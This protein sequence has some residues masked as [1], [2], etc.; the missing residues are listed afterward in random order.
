MDITAEDSEGGPRIFSAPEMQ[1]LDAAV[2]PE[3]GLDIVGLL[4]QAGARAGDQLPAERPVRSNKAAAK[5]KRPGAPPSRPQTAKLGVKDFLELTDYTVPEFSVVAVKATLGR[6]A[7]AFADL[8][9]TRNWMRNVPRRDGIGFRRANASLV[10][11][12]AV[13][14]NPWTVIIRSIFRLGAEDYAL[15]V[16]DAKALS[17]RLKTKAIAFVR[18]SKAESVGYD[19]FERGR[20]AEHAQWIERGSVCWFQSRFRRKP[21][22][23]DLPEQ[24]TDAVFRQQG[25]YLPACYPRRRGDRAWLCA[26]KSSAGAIQRADV[27]VLPRRGKRKS[28]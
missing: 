26:E 11:A 7:A 25:L 20:A 8:R 5:T 23:E 28:P 2:G 15:A 10:A 18:E 12:V 17:A 6:T 16:A 22:K 4:L 21:K 14:R 3:A 24:F 19:I 27:L 13:K 9:K 1:P